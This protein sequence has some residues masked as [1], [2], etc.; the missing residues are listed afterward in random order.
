MLCVQEFDINFNLTA[1]FSLKKIL[2]SSSDLSLIGY[3]W[4]YKYYWKSKAFEYGEFKMRLKFI[5]KL[6]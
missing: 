1:V 6:V 2:T 5:K 4:K 3:V